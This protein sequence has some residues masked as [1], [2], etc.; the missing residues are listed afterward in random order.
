MPELHYRCVTRIPIF[1][2]DLSTLN[3]DDTVIQAFELITDSDAII[4]AFRGTQCRL[5][6]LHLLQCDGK[7]RFLNLQNR[8]FG[9]QSASG[10]LIKFGIRRWAAGGRGTWLP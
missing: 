10:I 9:R 2:V 6:A 5:L 4:D 1:I 7:K 8:D 3:I